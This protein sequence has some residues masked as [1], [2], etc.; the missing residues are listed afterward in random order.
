MWKRCTHGRALRG[1]ATARL[2]VLAFYYGVSN[3]GPTIVRS[4]HVRC[5]PTRAAPSRSVDELGD[6]GGCSWLWSR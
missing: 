5:A 4:R 2:I 3:V 1:S 6:C